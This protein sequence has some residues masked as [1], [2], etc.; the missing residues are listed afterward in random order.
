[1]LQS[2]FQDIVTY[3]PK[4]DEGM[5]FDWRVRV[6]VRSA[7]NLVIENN[8]EMVPN[9]TIEVGWNQFESRPIETELNPTKIIPNSRHPIWNTQF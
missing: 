2:G 3:L 9:S 6:D 5:L 4:P 7:T 1:M 8:V